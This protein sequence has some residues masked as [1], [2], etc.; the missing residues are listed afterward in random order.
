MKVLLDSVCPP[1]PDGDR[2]LLGLLLNTRGI[3]GK[4]NAI[5]LYVFRDHHTDVL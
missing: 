3:T 4:A 1:E 2:L 5:Y